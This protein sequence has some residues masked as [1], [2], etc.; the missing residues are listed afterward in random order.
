[1]SYLMAHSI[2]KTKKIDPSFKLALSLFL[3]CITVAQFPYMCLYFFLLAIKTFPFT[4]LYNLYGTTSN[5]D[6]KKN[7]NMSITL[8]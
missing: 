8:I 3:L 6:F 4:L 5:L 7:G 1:M 2:N